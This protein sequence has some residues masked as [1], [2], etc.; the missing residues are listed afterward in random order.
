MVDKQK[1]K[2]LKTIGGLTAAPLLP[3]VAMGALPPEVISDQ[4][5]NVPD[6]NARG[7]QFGKF[8]LGDGPLQPYDTERQSIF[9]A[10]CTPWQCNL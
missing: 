6:H 10:T 5:G 8:T 4:S 3:V 9:A 7:P 1:R 2:T